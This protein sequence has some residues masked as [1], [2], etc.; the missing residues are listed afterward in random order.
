M[1]REKFQQLLAKARAT[2]E[3][4]KKREM[5]EAATA[6]TNGMDAQRVTEVDT[7]QLGITA[8]TLKTPEGE[9]QAVETIKEIL[10]RPIF[11][12]EEHVKSLEPGHKQL[13]VARDDI[14]L[15]DKQSYFNDLVQAGGN[16]VLIGAA[17]TGKTTSMRTVTKNLV[18]SGRIK[19][20]TE[21]SKWL[22][23]GKP[24]A[25]ILSYTRKAVNNIRHAVDDAFKQH[26]ITI[27]K[28]L[29]FAPIFYEI[30]DPDKPGFFK[31]TM[32]FE[33]QR[34]AGN[35][36]PSGLTFL[37]FEESSMISVELKALL[38][39]AMPH[40]HQEIFLGDIQQLPPIFGL[41]VLGFKMLELE[42]VELT[43]VYRQALN[44]P[45]ISLAWKILGGNPHD[46]SPKTEKYESFSKVLNKN[47]SR[48]RC[49]VLEQYS[50]QSP[51]GEVKFQVW[52]KQL[53]VDNGLNTFVKQITT[54]GDQGYYNPEDDI[55][56]C[57]FN[58]SFG[59]IE[60]NKGISQ[61]LGAKRQAT[62]Y[63][64]VAGFNKHYLAVGDRVLYDKEDAFIVSITVNTE[65][66]GKSAMPPSEHL[67]RW[68][69][70]R[71]KFSEEDKLQHQIEDSAMTEEAIERFMAASVDDVTERVQAASHAV[72]IKYAYSDEEEELRGAAEINNLLGGY[73]ITVHKAQGSEYD[74]VFLVL[75]NSH[76]VMCNRE[77]LYT[78]TTRAK[79]FLHVIC[80]TDTFYKGIRSQ[81]IKGNTIAEKAE[82]FKGKAT[83]LE[84]EK[85][86]E[87]LSHSSSKP[88]NIVM[89]SNK[90]AIKLESLVPEKMRAWGE[91]KL[92]VMWKLCLLKFPELTEATFP[93]PELAYNLGTG[94]VLG[95]ANYRKH[96]IFLNPVWCAAAEKDEAV[97]H[98]MYTDT[99]IHELCHLIAKAW[100]N[101]RGHGLWWKI[102]M[103]RMGVEPTR[104]YTGDALPPW[105]Q[106]KQQLLTDIFA[107]YKAGELEEVKEQPEEEGDV[108]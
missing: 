39:D 8:E 38:D 10:E 13:G 37:A 26:T 52:Q 77:L 94:R 82:W 62:V 72:I 24:G 57:P 23:A 98:E 53:S 61:H 105:T 3:A 79:K 44:S 33:P 97:K 85:A 50:K 1:D 20:L 28:L 102:A 88:S 71:E 6:L 45:I 69:H 95:R 84:K 35:P 80:E 86:Q 107:K 2:A 101:E 21:G 41:A 56:L 46:F 66:L 96:K 104:V 40:P 93:K 70:Y 83:D 27:H 17:G 5:E 31:N 64:V 29:E 90:P 106:E 55:V 89:V 22:S 15:N 108:V 75:H 87:L 18:H 12:S 51:E 7:S 60:I 14:I 19:A 100:K 42:V 11:G 16:C 48:I 103:K 63:E 92:D 49:P 68:G 99:L 58:K 43:E 4:A 91:L 36:L 73:A 9:E 67:D 65:Y 78:A 54:W 47:V 81:R 34:N 74:K 25:A 30:E 59:T 32:R 76:A